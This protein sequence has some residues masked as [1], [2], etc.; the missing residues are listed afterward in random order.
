MSMIESLEYFVL[1]NADS[2]EA[3]PRISVAIGSTVA[4]LGAPDALGGG[5]AVVLYCYSEERNGWG[6]VGLLGGAKVG[7]LK[8]IRAL[9][10]SLVAFGDTVVVGA[11]GDKDT[12]GQ[13]FVLR[14]PYGVWTYTALPVVN[15][16]SARDPARGDQF[17]ASV[18]HCS[19]GTD[20]YIAV[21][22]PGVAPPRGRTATGQVFIFKGVES[23]EPWSASPIINPNPAGTSADQFGSAVAINP[24]GDGSHHWDGTMTL[25]V[26][27]PG[28]DEGQGAV[29]VG[30]TAE[31]GKWT[32]FNFDE[33]LVPVFPD[34]DED[35]RTAGFGTCVALTGGATL[36]VGSPNDPNFDE[37]I[38]GTGAV[39][40]YNYV[41]GA[42]VEGKTRLYGGAEG[43]NLGS[44]V[45][46]PET[47]PEDDGD[48]GYALPQAQFLLVGAPGAVAGEPACA[49]VYG[50]DVESD[51]P[52]GETFSLFTEL[53]N[54]SR[55][56]GDQ[57]GAAVAASEFQNG[58]W[59]LVG[60]P[61][62]PS[63]SIAG[64]G[65]LYAHGEPAPTWMDFPTLVEGTGLRWGALD[66]EAWK[67]FT[68]KIEKYLT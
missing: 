5:G 10:S 62:D 31:P 61:G 7:G 22:A 56:E 15:A 39:W 43:R 28:A 2:G 50:N 38:E 14:P 32:T 64:G 23:T 27:A 44:S 68:P 52:A 40:T 63:S 37:L 47:T 17:G 6:Y 4:A 46:F 29:F 16:F 12:P 55:Q 11:A 9:G 66:V 60:V 53:V 30:R 45:A 3:P 26:G 54:S 34:A 65:Y 35:F 41:D 1:F 42:F 18:A 19:D 8:A 36:A 58:S 21:G 13:V 20:D 57:F 59:S 67:R 24:S 49:Y 51:Q 33:P 25:A 48:G